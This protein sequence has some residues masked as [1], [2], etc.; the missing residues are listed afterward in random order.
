MIQIEHLTKRFGAVVAVD[1]LSVAVEPGRVT[2]LLGPNGAGK[3]TTMSIVLGLQGATSGR[4][5]VGGRPY[6]SLE[7]PLHLVGALLDADAVHPARTARAHLTWVAQ[8]NMIAKSRVDHL[9]TVVGLESVADRRVRTYSLGMKQRLGIAQALLG[10]AP[11]LIFDEP[12]NG[13]DPEGIE[14]L[15]DLLKQLAREGRTVLVSSHLM[16][17]MSLTAGH[18]IVIGRGRLLADASLPDFIAGHTHADLVVRTPSPDLLTGLLRTH[19]ATVTPGPEHLVVEG[20]APEAVGEIAAQ[21]GI[22]LHE[23]RTRT[24]TLEDAYLALTRESVQ[25]GSRP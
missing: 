6:A 14:W 2:G 12:T 16:A 24:A 25:F 13:L 9:L 11:V 23:L 19:G 3:T 10:D 1:D 18:L 20:L 17:E 7:R 22:V 21:A 5:L 15:R 4:A 8:T